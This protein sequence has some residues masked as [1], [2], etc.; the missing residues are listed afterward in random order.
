MKVFNDLNIPK[1]EYFLTGSRAL[2]T[3]EIKFSTDNSDYDYV[4]LITQR[5][6][7]IDYLVS[8]QIQID[9]SCYNGGFKFTLDG[10]T[11]NIITTIY[12]EFKAWR[13]ALYILRYLISVDKFYAVALTNKFSRYCCYES[14]RAFI[15][16]MLSLGKT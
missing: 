16:T 14:L 8:S 5:H 2:D 9:Y 13:E 4:V 3:E 7:I 1:E 6:H 11:Y 15:K 12:C 10:K